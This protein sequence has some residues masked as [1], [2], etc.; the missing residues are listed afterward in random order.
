MKKIILLI[1][2]LI[3]GIVTIIPYFA[4][5]EA[6]RQFGYFN[7]TFYPTNNLK[8]LDSTYQR[9]WFHSV[10]Q[11]RFETSEQ[12]QVA[13]NKA[14]FVF[15]HEIEH[16]FVPIQPTVVHS[17]LY[18]AQDF[19]ASPSREMFD[20]DVLLE[21]QTKVEMNGDNLSTL[22]TPAL[23]IEDDGASLQWQGLQGS[24][25]VKQNVATVQAEIYTPQIQ[26]DTDQG[27]IVIQDITFNADMQSANNNVMQGEGH[28][29]IANAQIISKQVPQVKLEGIELV[30]SHNVVN[31]Y[32]TFVLKTGLQQMQVGVDHYGPGYGDIELR[33]W[34]LP[35]LTHIKNT[36]AERR[37][38]GMTLT[39]RINAAKFQLMPLGLKFLNKSPELALTR[40]NINTQ[41]GELQARLRV[42]ME[43]F[44]GGIFLLFNPTLLLNALN[45]QL[46]IFLP[47]SLLDNSSL[48]PE[49]IRA[50]LKMWVKKGF[51]VAS[52]EEPGY[53]HSQ[54]QLSNGI[55]QVNGQQLPITNV[56]R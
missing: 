50:Y 28:L 5:I 35:T 25:E 54:M 47:Q 55:L 27:Q 31:E 26:L 10:A 46:E 18:L 56:F 42:K 14:N 34:H 32:L 4:G 11:S 49:T 51:L 38:Q 30:G 23:T 15:L 13:D 53:Y 9:G 3:L 12:N 1:I 48:A 39:Q 22:R 6:S 45:A 2:S 43:P 33:H 8:L 44:E 36:L 37:Y 52:N 24:I 19:Q 29:N 20:H 21:V 17:R 16:G 40:L 41:E 7:Q